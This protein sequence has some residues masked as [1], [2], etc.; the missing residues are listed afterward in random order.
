MSNS[1]QLYFSWSELSLV[2]CRTIDV[3]VIQIFGG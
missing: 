1:R 3:R 2:T